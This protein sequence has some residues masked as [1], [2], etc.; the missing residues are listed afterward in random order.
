[1]KSP[2]KYP[3]LITY[4]K[5]Y[6]QGKELRYTLRSLQNL[7]N[8]D[9]QVFIVGDKENWFQNIVHIP[10]RHS[11]NSYIN[12]EYAMMA[13]L[14][15]PRLPDD[16][17]YSM[18]DVYICEPV[19][20]TYMHQGEITPYRKSYHE[21]QKLVTKEWLEA[22][23]CTTLDYELHT[24]MLHN[25]QKR[26]EVNKMIAPTLNRIMLKPRTVYGNYFGVGGQFYLDQKTRIR[27][28]PSDKIISTQFFVAELI[29]LF[30]NPCNFEITG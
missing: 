29:E 11:R 7:L 20:V 9:G 17:L 25:R 6:D 3:I 28:L 30:P 22:Q 16:F 8:W 1:M 2:S 5:T 23:G 14:A 27:K 24:P 26:I 13:A 15:D 18:D 4:R 12:Q 19:E 10:S 21:K